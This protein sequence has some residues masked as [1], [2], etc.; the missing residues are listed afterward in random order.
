MKYDLTHVAEVGQ[1]FVAQAPKSLSADS[2]ASIRLT[3]YTP[4]SIEYDAQCTAPGMVVFSEVYY[5]YGWKALVDGQPVEH[6]RVNYILRAL[7]LEAG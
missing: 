4:E 5:P 7:N 1:D 3:E 6:Y 2:T